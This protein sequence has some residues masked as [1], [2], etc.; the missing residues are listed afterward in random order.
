[1]TVGLS[2][3]GDGSLEILSGGL[4]SG[5]T[6]AS[7]QLVVDSGGVA[8]GTVVS[9]GGGVVIASGGS[10]N[11]ITIAGGKVVI[12]GNPGGGAGVTFAAGAAGVLD[13]ASASG[14]FAPEISGLND[15]DQKIELG[16]F[17]FSTGEKVTW[18]QSGT[19][20][21]LR[22]TDG[23]QVATLR[24]VGTY[25]TSDFKLATDGQ[26]GPS[27]PTLGPLRG[28]PASSRPLRA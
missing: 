2:D 12:S 22:V 25:V 13:L 18:T 4:A 28:S 14:L 3:V 19:S 26:A 27:F 11:G 17:A 23:A 10:L 21:S 24:L 8:T 15:P 1:V 16:G 7:G 9:S 20:G 6:V 5:V